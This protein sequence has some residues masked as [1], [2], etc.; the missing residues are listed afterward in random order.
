[1]KTLSD[2]VKGML[3]MSLSM[4][5][6]TLADANLKMASEY[7]STGLITLALGLGGTILFWI[8][9]ARKGEPLFSSAIFES[10]VMLR[11]VGETVATIFMVMALTYSSFIAVTVIVQTLPLLLTLFSLIFLGEKVG[12]QRLSA[13]LL[14]FCGMLVIMRPGTDGFDIFSLFAVIAVMGMAMRDIGSR[15]AAKHHSSVRL[16]TF[17]TMAQ[18]LAGIVFMLFEPAPNWPPMIAWVYLFG[19]ISL[20]SFAIILVTKAMRI[21]EVSAVSPFRYTRLLF[22]ILAGVII[23][24]DSLD[25]FTILGSIIILLAG[26]YIWQREQRLD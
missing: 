23:F 24:G 16:A 22:G 10:P 7:V 6:F 5:G 4:A 3:L 2:N 18:T 15:L 20:A 14:G 19:M 26:L 13:V 21:G 17:G 25:N 1:M 11:T 8:M 12:I 9:L